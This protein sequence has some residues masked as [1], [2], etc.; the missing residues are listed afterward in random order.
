MAVLDTICDFAAEHDLVLIGTI[1]LIGAFLASFLLKTAWGLWD[2][3][4]ARPKYDSRGHRIKPAEEICR[5][6]LKVF[7]LSKLTGN[8]VTGYLC[9]N[10][11][12]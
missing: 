6:C 2:N 3:R 5:G 4:N 7:R 10:C 12:K 8:Q 11:R 1:G 9:R